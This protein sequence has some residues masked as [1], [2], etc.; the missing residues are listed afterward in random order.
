SE[1]THAHAH[2]S[3]RTIVVT[4]GAGH[5]GSHLI[6]LLV[7]ESDARV[8]SLDNYSNGR[9]ENHIAGAE[10]REGHTRDIRTRIPE[11]PD[12]LFHLGE[13]ARIKTSFEDVGT[14]YESNMVGTFNV[15]EFCRE[16]SVPK[17]VYAASSTKFAI[18]GDGRHQNPY[19]FTKATNVDLIN[20]YGRWYGLP[21]AI[22]YFYNAFG[23]REV[24][25]G[26]YATLIA[27]F[28]TLY[29]KG[30][31]LTVASP[32]TQRRAFTYVKDLARGILMVGEKGNGDG[33]ALR[34][35]NTYSIMEIAA[36]FG[37][38]IEMIEEYTGRSDVANDPNKAREE[39]GWEPTLDVLDYIAEYVS[40]V[41]PEFVT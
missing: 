1:L 6:E 33:Y 13:Y 31:P 29:R 7:A 19:S 24:G 2:M 12:M 22:C 17:L 41:K 5:V 20:D 38:R 30:L 11:T 18:E 21:Y 3:R 35:A 8:I 15:T 4:G 9:R 23:P 34:A 37:G 10:Y 32:G 16:R 27:L 36:A 28:E 25:E 26:K 39:L 14:V 40:R